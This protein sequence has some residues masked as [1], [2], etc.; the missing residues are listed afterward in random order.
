MTFL[1]DEVFDDGLEVLTDNVDEIHICSEEPVDYTG[2]TSTYTL[3]DRQVTVNNPE[4]LPEG[5]GRRVTVDS[6]S[7]GNSTSDG[8][9]TH[10]ALV[11]TSDSKLY[12][13]LELADTI[14]ID[15]TEDWSLDEVSIGIPL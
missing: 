2:A 9:G 3:G 5:E 4:D 12:A 14:E 11:D 1:A 8:D 13:V 10:I 15:T 7:D 6:F